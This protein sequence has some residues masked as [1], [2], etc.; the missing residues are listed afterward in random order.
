MLDREDDTGTEAGDDYPRP[1]SRCAENDGVPQAPQADHPRTPRDGPIDRLR[2]WSERR[3]PDAP[4]EEMAGVPVRGRQGQLHAACRADRR[5]SGRGLLPVDI[6]ACNLD[7]GQPGFPATVLPEFLYQDGRAPHRIE[8]ADTYSIVVDKVPQGR[9][10]CALCSRASGAGTSTESRGEEGCFRRGFSAHHRDDIP[11]DL[12]PQPLPMAGSWRRMPPNGFSTTRAIS[13]CCARWPMWRR[14]DCERFS[15]AMDYP[16]IPCDLCGKSGRATTAG[17]QTHARR[18][19]GQGPRPAAEA[20]FSAADE[21]APLSH[22]LDPALFDFAGL[23]PTRSTIPPD[24]PARR[25]SPPSGICPLVRPRWIRPGARSGH[26]QGG[27]RRVGTLATRLAF[28]A[29]PSGGP[30]ALPDPCPLR[31]RR[32]RP[33]ARGGRQ[34]WCCPLCWSYQNLGRPV[35]PGVFAPRPGDTRPR[36][37]PPIAP[38]CWPCWAGYRP[39]RDWKAPAFVLAD[40]RLGQARTPPRRGGRA[41]SASDECHVSGLCAALRG[42]D[43]V[44]SLGPATFGVVLHPIAAATAED[45]RL[46]SRTGCVPVL[47][48]PVAVGRDLRAAHRLRRARRVAEPGALRQRTLRTPMPCLAGAF[49]ALEEGP[50]GGSRLRPVPSCRDRRGGNARS[51]SCPTKVAGALASGAILPWFQPQLDMRTGRVAGFEGAGALA[52]PDAGR[53]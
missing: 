5:F 51:P 46:R 9:T 21:R 34:P 52:A 24:L 47:A 44:A 18:V 23:K 31:L 53:P 22:L 13:S 42:D 8:Y 33:D 27:E 10:Y 41:R 1:L 40:R 14:P 50:R 20:V 11:R 19:G 38:R 4:R 12:L 16:I 28:G 35:R 39:C 7:Q 6:L 36:R 2:H 25:L 15:R 45:P 17:H 29:Q 37:D 43:L 49:Q 3:A 48:T 32:R 30:G 26:E